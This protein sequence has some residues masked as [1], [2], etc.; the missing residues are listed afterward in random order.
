MRTKDMSLSGKENLKYIGSKNRISKY[1]VPILQQYINENNISTYYEPFVGGANIIDKIKC[2]VK[3]G[4]DIHS[5]LIAMFL[6]LQNGWNP[7]EHI[8]EEEYE[9]VRQNKEKYP[10]YY[11]GFVGFNYILVDMQ[12]IL[13]LMVL[14]KEI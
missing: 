14:L 12:E 3:V 10:E 9:M 6:A 11:V 8:T 5:Q 7:P 1:I 2:N 13:N 4:N